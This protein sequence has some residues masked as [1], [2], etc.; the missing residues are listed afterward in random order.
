MIENYIVSK[1][2]TI[3]ALR[4]HAYPTAAPVGECKPPFA[5]YTI[6]GHT[7]TRDIY[8]NLIY[9]TDTVRVDLYHD[10]NDALGAIAAEAEA[11]MGAQ[12]QEFEDM[13]IYSC[14]AT[15]SDPDGFDMNLA[16][17]RKTLSVAVQYWR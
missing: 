7:P 5:I 6:L 13:Y 1:L 15:G 16:M 2:D 9:Y 11:A 17:H 14:T 12:N 3:Q 10:D 8:D 4:G